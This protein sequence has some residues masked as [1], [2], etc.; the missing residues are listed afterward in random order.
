MKRNDA[1]TTL[2][3]TVVAMTISAM[4]VGAVLSIMFASVKLLRI[5]PPETN[6]HTFGALASAVARLE[7]SVTADVTCANPTTAT[8][9]TDCLEVVNATQTPVPHPDD[10]DVLCW[11]VET[12]SGRRRECWEFLPQGDLIVHRYAPDPAITNQ[13]DLLSINAW[14]P[15]VAETLP[16]ASGLA[17]LEWDTS[18][19]PVELLGCSLI[20]QERLILLEPA[21]VPFCDGRLGLYAP[22]GTER[23]GVKG[24]PMP[25]LQVRP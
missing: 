11:V 21:E 8:T 3:E 25:P 18:S 5:A 15:D 9:R 6:P 16:R 7:K 24:H 4:M 19:D 2:S 10:S 13:A 14:S 17:A 12:D 1:G 22:D 23:T 20:R